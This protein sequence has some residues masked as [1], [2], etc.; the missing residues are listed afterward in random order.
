M[1]DSWEEIDFSHQR[2]IS[3][4]ISGYR[5]T[6]SDVVACPRFSQVEDIKKR[7]S[8]VD[9][10]TIQG[11]PG[12]GKSI[13][14]YQAAYDFYNQ[15]YRVF[16]LINKDTDGLVYLPLISEKAI[17]IVDD[18]QNLP[19]YIV[20]KVCE[21]ANN[22]RKI[23]LTKTLSEKSTYES[24]SLTN[25]DAVNEIRNDYM[26]RQA[27]I[28]QIVHVLDSDIGND[29]FKTSLEYRLSVAGKAKTPW[30]FNYIL[31]GGWQGMRAAYE[32]VSKHKKVVC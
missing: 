1:S 23:I 20:D 27:E 6:A 19:L 3:Y 25:D 21:Q 16:K 8:I 22:M 12:C 18:A 14:V 2:S 32:E 5:L 13:S 28:S 29:F 31:R 4:A 30:Q 15:G 26:N 24:I 11:E 10:V 17:Y 7:L 9:Y